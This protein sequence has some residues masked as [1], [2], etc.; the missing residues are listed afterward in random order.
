MVL[1]IVIAGALLT[2]VVASVGLVVRDMCGLQRSGRRLTDR[3]VDAAG[4]S[5][6]AMTFASQ[7][8]TH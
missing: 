5:P 4:V 1:G 3:P 7:Q 8:G 2:A 6:A